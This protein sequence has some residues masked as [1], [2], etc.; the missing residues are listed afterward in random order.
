MTGASLV[1]MRG[2]SAGYR[3]ASGWSWY[4]GRPNCGWKPGTFSFESPSSGKGT[5]THPGSALQEGR[6]TLSSL[7]Q[8]PLPSFPSHLQTPFQMVPELD[9]AGSPLGA[10][11][12]SGAPHHH[13]DLRLHHLL[14]RAPVRSLP[15]ASQAPTREATFLSPS[16]LP[17]SRCACQGGKIGTK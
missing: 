14:L 1:L 9:S 12:P 17:L 10:C 3:A 15:C 2:L 8:G 11:H 6:E 5:P 13:C 4:P 16:F 7:R